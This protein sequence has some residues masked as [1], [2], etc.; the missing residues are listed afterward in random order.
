MFL[1]QYILTNFI[2]KIFGP[3][4][5]RKIKIL[6]SQSG[7]LEILDKLDVKNFDFKIMFKVTNCDLEDVIK[8]IC[9]CKM[10]LQVIK[11]G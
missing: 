7:T 11:R 6:K 9:G 2:N 10:R 3:I 1:R 4:C 5:D 8:D